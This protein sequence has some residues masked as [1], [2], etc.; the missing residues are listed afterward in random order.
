MTL[1]QDQLRDRTRQRHRAHLEPADEIEIVVLQRLVGQFREQPA[2]RDRAWSLQLKIEIA[3][4]TRARVIS[5][6][7]TIACE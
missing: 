5:P 6:R 3:L 2:L 7:P 1:I 4:A